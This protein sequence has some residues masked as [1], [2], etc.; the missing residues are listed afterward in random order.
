MEF[1]TCSLSLNYFIIPDT[2]HS[3]RKFQVIQLIDLNRTLGSV[4]SSPFRKEGCRV[5]GLFVTEYCSFL[6]YDI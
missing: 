1:K 6:N 4:Y 2:L 5:S 3:L